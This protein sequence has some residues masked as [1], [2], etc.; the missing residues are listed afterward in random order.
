MANL[1][2]DRHNSVVAVTFSYARFNS[3]SE[4][5]ELIE[6]E[7]APLALSMAVENTASAGPHVTSNMG[8]TYSSRKPVS[9]VRTNLVLA[10]PPPT[11]LIPLGRDALLVVVNAAE[12]APLLA[13]FCFRR[14]RNK[15]SVFCTIRY[16]SLR[17]LS[18]LVLSISLYWFPNTVFKPLVTLAT[19]TLDVDLDPSTFSRASSSSFRLIGFS[20]MRSNIPSSK[21]SGRSLPSQIPRLFR[22]NPL[23]VM[24]RSS[25]IAGL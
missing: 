18:S 25:L 13:R 11:L 15:L 24:R 9:M 8:V 12:A 14:W 2:P 23:L 3:S 16:C 4:D 10:V 17:K 1:K 5:M 21:A 22:R 6:V 7:S 20:L 19:P